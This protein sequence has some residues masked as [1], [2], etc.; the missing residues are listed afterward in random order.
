[1][2]KCYLVEL[3]ISVMF[4]HWHFPVL[5]PT[6]Q[7]F[8]PEDGCI[9]QPAQRHFQQRKRGRWMMSKKKNSHELLNTS[10]TCFKDIVEM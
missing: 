7:A 3:Q 5:G 2:F 1:M 6:E 8:L 10:V 9:V 4:N